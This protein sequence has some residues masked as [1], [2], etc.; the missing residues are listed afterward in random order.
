MAIWSSAATS[1]AS[2]PAAVAAGAIPST[3]TP[4]ALPPTCAT[5]L[6]PAPA[7]RPTMASCSTTPAAPSM[8]PPPPS[9]G[10][11]APP[12]SYSIA[13]AITTCWPDVQAEQT[14]GRLP[15]RRRYGRNL[16]RRHPA[17]SG[18]GSAVDDQDL[19]HPR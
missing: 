14:R 10:R 6:S 4:N 3:A 1:C 11:L 5:A 2:K 7:P 19:L 18:L 17:R 8:P 13:T 12:P 15:D 16:H 9:G